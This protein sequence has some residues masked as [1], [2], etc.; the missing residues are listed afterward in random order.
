MDHELQLWTYIASA[1]LLFP[2]FLYILWEALVTLWWRPR[3]IRKMFEGQGIPCLP[4]HFYHGNLPE[5]VA[6]NQDA[7]RKM[8]SHLIISHDIAPLIMPQYYQWS[9][10]FGELLYT[11]SQ[12]FSSIF[13]K[14]PN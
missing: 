7:R 2:L 12:V 8:P 5:F 14:S 9:K 6:I 3:R 10:T 13:A 1:I 4:Y 11:L